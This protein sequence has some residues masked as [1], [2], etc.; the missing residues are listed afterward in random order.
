MHDDDEDAEG[1]EEDDEDDS[2]RTVTG[3]SGSY[4]DV[5]LSRLASTE[6]ALRDLSDALLALRLALEILTLQGISLP[7]SLFSSEYLL[8]VVSSLRRALDACLVPILEAPPTSPLAELASHRARDKVADVTDALVQGTQA[9]AALIRAEELSDE[10]VIALAYFS[11][12]P[13]FHEAPLATTAAARAAAAKDASPAVNAIKSLR[14]ASLAVVQAVY[15]RYADQRAWIVE[16]V[17][18]NLGKAESA[19]GSAAA[20]KAARRGIRCVWRGA[21]VSLDVRSA[22]E[23]RTAFAPGPRSRPSLPCSSTSCRRAPPTSSRRSA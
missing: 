23:T 8:G 13:F 11:L 19:T 18:S 20:K 7:K 17:L 14:L 21:P 4:W 5:D 15:S 12:E 6:A 1:E 16:E 22:D 2:Q 3:P 9:L 10:L